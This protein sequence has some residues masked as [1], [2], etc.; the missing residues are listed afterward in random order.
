MWLLNIDACLFVTPVSTLS[1]S[2]LKSTSEKRYKLVAGRQL[3][4]DVC[5]GIHL[6][7]FV[8]MQVIQW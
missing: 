5:A 4:P 1:A 3:K 2:S 6:T 8:G 7:S